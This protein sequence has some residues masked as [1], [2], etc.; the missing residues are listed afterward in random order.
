MKKNNLLFGVELE[1]AL[2]KR[3]RNEL[4]DICGNIISDFSHFVEVKEDGSLERWG[5][6][7]EYYEVGREIVTIPAPLQDQLIFW[8]SFYRKYSRYL[9]DKYREVGMHVHVDKTSFSDEHIAKI[10]KFVINNEKTMCRIGGREANDYLY[11]G[12]DTPNDDHY[13]AVN[14]SVYH[15]TIEFR[16][17]DS[18]IKYAK[19]AQNLLRVN[20]IVHF[21]EV[22]ER[23]THLTPRR[24]YSF[25]RKLR[26]ESTLCLTQ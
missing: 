14:L 5:D 25:A 7:G 9:S 2:K 15:P 19:F 23:R 17:F 12:D 4:N 22:I 21:T 8:R 26:E 11:F 6:D 16:L 3:H 1:F 13:N 24:F 20:E 10:F 18:P